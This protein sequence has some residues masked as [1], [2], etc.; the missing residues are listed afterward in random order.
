MFS[1]QTSNDRMLAK[2]G[3]TNRGLVWEEGDGNDGWLRWGDVRSAGQQLAEWSAF[4]R[5]ATSCVVWRRRRPVNSSWGCC[6]S[7]PGGDLSLL[8]E[9]RQTKTNSWKGGNGTRDRIPLTALTPSLF[10]WFCCICSFLSGRRHI[11]IFDVTFILPVVCTEPLTS[12]Y[13]FWGRNLRWR[14][15]FTS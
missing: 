11:C 7:T 15:D 14:R 1:S 10:L 5:G 12:V 8:L 9:W 6:H 13:L 2:K 3:K 4:V